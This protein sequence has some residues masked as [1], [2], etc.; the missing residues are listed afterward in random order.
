SGER[1]HLDRRIEDERDPVHE[2]LVLRIE[3][4][5]ELREDRAQLLLHRLRPDERREERTV[6]RRRW[7]LRRDVRVLSRRKLAL[8]RRISG[9]RLL[10]IGLLGIRLLAVRRLPSVIRRRLLV[11]LL[12]TRAERERKRHAEDEGKE[13]SKRLSHAPRS[14]SFSGLLADQDVEAS[15]AGGV[16]A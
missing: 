16:S 13:R 11:R 14:Y 2:R 8:R 4:V 10:R 15:E 9:I 3:R 6:R 1:V 12:L 5:D 7:R